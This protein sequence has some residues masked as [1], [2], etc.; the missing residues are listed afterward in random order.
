MATFAELQC[1][2]KLLLEKMKRMEIQYKKELE[3]Q[4]EQFGSLW[5]AIGD[6]NEIYWCKHCECYYED[7]GVCDCDGEY[8]CKE[9]LE[10]DDCPF[11]LCC[12]C[13]E[14]INL[15]YRKKL[16]LPD[17]N[18]CCDFC[19]KRRQ[20][21]IY[22]DIDMDAVMTKPCNQYQKE[23]VLTQLLKKFKTN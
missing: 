11:K 18:I 15:N 4:R 6:D 9:C 14:G 2:N 10:K 3:K 20:Y 5:D 17:G 8:C 1:F 16:T 12:D 22:Y 23:R 7:D 21:E 19:F 13:D